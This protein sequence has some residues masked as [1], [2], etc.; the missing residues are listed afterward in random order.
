[1]RPG[2]PTTEQRMDKLEKR[3]DE[4][5]RLLELLMRMAKHHPIGQKM[6]AWLVRENVR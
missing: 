3:L 6:L 1:M 5:D 2:M 4:Y